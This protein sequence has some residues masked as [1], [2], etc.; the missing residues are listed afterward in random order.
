MKTTEGSEFAVRFINTYCND[1]ETILSELASNIKDPGV[2]HQKK[3]DPGV[4][5][6]KLAEMVGQVEKKSSRIGAEHVR[7]A[8]TNLKQACDEM[9]ESH[10]LRE[11]SWTKNEFARTQNTLQV[12]IQM[13]RRIIKLEAKQ[14][15]RQ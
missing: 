2:V 7:F 8:C 4:D 5:F 1:V 15:Q 13:E 10:F 12:I 6:S 11:L 9:N 14:R 3:E